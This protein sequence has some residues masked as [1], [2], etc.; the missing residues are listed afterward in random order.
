MSIKKAAKLKKQRA[1]HRRN[2]KRSNNH[3]HREHA[4]TRS[5]IR[6]AAE[7]AAAEGE[8]VD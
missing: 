4:H 8:N 6:R 2:L 7:A 1:R 3:V 5:L